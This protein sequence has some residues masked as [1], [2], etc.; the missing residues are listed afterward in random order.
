MPEKTETPAPPR[1]L[2]KPMPEETGLKPG[3]IP[4]LPQP[5]STE[6]PDPPD[7]GLVA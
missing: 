4:P 6:L 3:E 7:E 1:P 2:D 5:G